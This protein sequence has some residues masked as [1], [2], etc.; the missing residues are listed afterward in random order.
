MHLKSDDAG[1]KSP[2]LDLKKPELE[3]H[4]SA[5]PQRDDDDEGRERPRMSRLE[6]TISKV[7]RDDFDSEGEDA[8]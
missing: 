8:V 5:I 1:K 3:R 7:P 4:I 2:D 6:R